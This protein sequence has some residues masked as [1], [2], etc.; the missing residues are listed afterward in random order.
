MLDDM[1]LLPTLLWHLDRYTYQTSIQV[2]FSQ[3]GLENRLPSE[4]E[5]TAYRIIQES[6]TNIARHAQV[7]RAEVNLVYTDE[8]VLTVRVTDQGHGFDIQRTQVAKAFGLAGMRERAFLVGGQLT[9]KSS[10]GKGTEI[11]AVLPVRGR[12]ERRKDDRKSATR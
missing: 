1:G 4:I 5:I 11:V 9:V 3:F 6:L 2:D 8:Q 7:N 12:L 10:P